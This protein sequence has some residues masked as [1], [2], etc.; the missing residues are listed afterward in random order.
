[1][2]GRLVAVAWKEAVRQ[3]SSV[4]AWV[5]LAWAVVS[6]RHL[7]Q[8]EAPAGRLPGKVVGEASQASCPAV[9]H[10][11]IRVCSVQAEGA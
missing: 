10:R 9:C 5:V 4:P 6:D 3:A 7:P 2:S 8:G 1:M 11:S